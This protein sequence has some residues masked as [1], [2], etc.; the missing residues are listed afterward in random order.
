MKEAG[1]IVLK[2]R[3]NEP[4]FF[5]EKVTMGSRFCTLVTT[6]TMA[7]LAGCGGGDSRCPSDT[8]L[9]CTTGKCCRR[10]YPYSCGDG[11]CYQFGCPPG[12]PQIGICELKLSTADPSKAEMEIS[13]VADEAAAGEAA[14][15]SEPQSELQ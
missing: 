13:P 14:P 2:I 15:E 7:L 12:S 8:P 10:G 3:G 4:L 11:F 5:D 1:C 6:I 9:E